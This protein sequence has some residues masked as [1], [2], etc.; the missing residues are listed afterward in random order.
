MNFRYSVRNVGRDRRRSDREI[1]RMRR[2][3]YKSLRELY[4]VPGER[5]GRR[6]FD[7][8]YTSRR[9]NFIQNL[10]ALG[11]CVSFSGPITG[12]INQDVKK[13]KFFSFAFFEI[14]I[15]LGDF[16]YI[17]RCLTLKI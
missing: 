11:W 5:R 8:I 6:E 14:K 7:K 9:V 16:R 12:A 1:N 13:K 17:V 3:N 10:F 2:K 4:Y 15:F